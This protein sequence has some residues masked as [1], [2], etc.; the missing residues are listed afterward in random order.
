[1]LPDELTIADVVTVSAAEVDPVSVTEHATPAPPNL[2]RVLD[3]NDTLAVTR[4]DR[5][6]DEAA[7]GGADHHDISGFA[8]CMVGV[9]SWH[10]PGA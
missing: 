3:Q 8:G 10:A 2:V 1:M 9:S 7:E 4:E 6:S 5:A